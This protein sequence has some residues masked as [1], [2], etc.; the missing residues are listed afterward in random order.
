MTTAFDDPK[1]F[2]VKSGKT[3]ADIERILNQGVEDG[4][5]LRFSNYDS[6]KKEHVVIM[7]F[8]DWDRLEEK[9][10]EENE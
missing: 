3:P 1:N 2:I 6:I 7:E 10:Y 5:S 4:Y 8:C 9:Y